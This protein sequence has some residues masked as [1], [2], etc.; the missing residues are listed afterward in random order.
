MRAVILAAGESRRLLELT[1][2]IPK[3]LLEV[4]GKSLLEHQVE[5][6]REA[7][8]DGITV[9]TGHA[10]KPLRDVGGPSLDYL[11]NAE[12]ATTNSIYSLWL[13]RDAAAGGFVLM[14]GDV[15]FDPRLLRR[16][17]SD[18][19]EDV[20]TYDPE[21]ILEEEEMKLRLEGN[22]VAEMSKDLDADRAHGENVGLLKFG[23]EGTEAL[24]TELEDIIAGGTVKTWAPFAFDRLCRK[25]PL[26]ALSTD[27]LPWIEI[28][29]PEDLERARRVVWPVI[30]AAAG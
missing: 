21:S 13:A 6:L 23:A 26:H 16:L 24:M 4:G 28:D 12:Y 10:E 29:F 5:A 8:V 1:R 25:R 19:R 3:C 9:V 7:G 20:L 2:D 11:R 27:G 14:N 17:L 15:L 22:R 18:P 30:E